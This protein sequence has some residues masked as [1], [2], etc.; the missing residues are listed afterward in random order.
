MLTWIKRYR[1]TIL[2]LILLMLLPL[3]VVF[4][5]GYFTLR[6]FDIG[7]PLQAAAIFDGTV[8]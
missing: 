6:D 1:Y 7:A 5:K 8:N 3:A 2:A 4:I